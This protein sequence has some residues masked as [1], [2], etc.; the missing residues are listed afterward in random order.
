MIGHIAEKFESANQGPGLIA[1]NPKDPGGASFGI[2]Q[3]SLKSGT[4]REFVNTSIF[5]DRLSDKVLGTPEFKTVW[6]QI[7]QG[8]PFEFRSDQYVFVFQRLF[9]P[10]TLLAAYS[11]YLTSSTKV[12]EALFSIAV[13]HHNY[14]E[15]IYGAIAASDAETQVMALYK[16]RAEYVSKLK[17]DPMILKSLLL[18]YSTEEKEILQLTEP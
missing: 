4:L 7:A 14:P 16:S 11:N 10:V 5:R 9:L 18:R 15:I 3:L 8:F 6:K 12:Q 13:Q 1:D 17:L 2:Y